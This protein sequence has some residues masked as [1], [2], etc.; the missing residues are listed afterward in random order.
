MAKGKVKTEE[1]LREAG[2]LVDVSFRKVGTTITISPKVLGIEVGSNEELASFFDKFV[3]SSQIS[4]LGKRNTQILKAEA[5]SKAVHKRKIR[6]SLDGKHYLPKSKLPG[7]KA[8]MKEKKTEFMKVR[9]NLV[10]SYELDVRSFR[11]K[12]EDDFLRETVTND[13]ERDQIIAAIMSKVPSKEELKNSFKVE[14]TYML[15]AMTSELM[16]EEDKQA[17][18]ESAQ[19]RM[20]E[21]NGNTLAL[22]FD[23]INLILEALVEKRHTKKH[24]QMVADLVEEITIRNIFSNSDLDAIKQDLIDVAITNTLDGYETII[25]TVYKTSR[26]I[27]E[28]HQLNLDTSI[29]TLKQ[30]EFM[31]RDSAA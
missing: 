11:R 24:K 20:N 15:F 27:Q 12:L 29:F 18:I 10:D 22:V 8:F 5:L 6:D 1:I 21:I 14:Q 17:S 2:Y 25:G 7:F 30:L 31:A 26:D 13:T 28:D 3:K 16:D 4:W 19:M 23:K 9:D